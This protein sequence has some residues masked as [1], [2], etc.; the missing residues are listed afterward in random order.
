MWLAWFSLVGWAASAA[1]GP[2]VVPSIQTTRP[3]GTSGITFDRRGF[4]QFVTRKWFDGDPDPDAI[5]AR[6]PNTSGK[7]A[8][9]WRPG[10]LLSTRIRLRAGVGEAEPSPELMAFARDDLPRALE[11]A[12][13][14][15]IVGDNG[16]QTVIRIEPR[17]TV[18][19]GSQWTAHVRVRVQRF[20]VVCLFPGSDAVQMT[21]Q[22]DERDV[23]TAAT[24]TRDCADL[25]AR[26]VAAWLR[27]TFTTVDD[28]PRR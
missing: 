15:R 5:Y 18:G 27:R 25:I 12:A 4:P 2:C 10:D 19:P 21:G 20:T 16:G 7:Y 26:A 13:P 3:S 24:S 9:L 1:L 22:M 8:A 14:V 28:K 11:N 23:E 6:L 17:L